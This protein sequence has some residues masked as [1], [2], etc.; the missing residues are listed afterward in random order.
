MD[1]ASANHF[2]GN[3]AAKK[4]AV[5]RLTKNAEHIAA[6]VSGANPRLMKATVYR[7][8]LTNGQQHMAVI[9][10]IG[11]GAWTEEAEMWDAMVSHVYTLTGTLAEGIAKQF[12]DQ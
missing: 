7:L 5:D 12:P 8:L 6:F 11:K 2:S 4:A 1:A 3:P 10:D 9:D